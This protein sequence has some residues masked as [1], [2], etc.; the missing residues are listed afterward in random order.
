MPSSDQVFKV[1][2]N[3]CASLPLEWHIVESWIQIG[4]PFFFCVKC[5]VEPE[6]TSTKAVAMGVSVFLSFI[7]VSP[8][9]SQVNLS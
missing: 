9:T 7:T 3:M 1:L 4:V 8:L 2:K 6:E 5:F